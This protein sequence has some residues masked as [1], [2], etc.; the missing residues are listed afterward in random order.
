MGAMDSVKID[1]D[2][3]INLIIETPM[4]ERS[5]IIE[6][7]YKTKVDNSFLT[8]EEVLVMYMYYVESMRPDVIARIL[9]KSRSNI[10]AALERVR[11]KYESAKETIKLIE[12]IMK[13]IRVSFPSGERADDA[14]MKLY[15]TADEK[16]IKVPYKSYQIKKYMR[17]K[18][19]IDDYDRFVND[20][21][22]II[23]P[24]IGIYHYPRERN[25]NK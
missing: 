14:L 18:H 21:E 11:V 1:T 16:A 15:T 4:E 25:E 5:R 24:G 13:S 8:V 19:I 7:N 17:K 20:T 12:G 9:G 23:L 22:L 6:E 3:L 10:Y 2:E